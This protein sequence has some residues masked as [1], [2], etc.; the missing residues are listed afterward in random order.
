MSR[1]LS[2]RHSG[3]RVHQGCLLGGDGILSGINS[4]SPRIHVYPE[5]QDVTIF[6]NRV[7][8]DVIR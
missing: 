4:A 2:L 1:W 7:F 6:R 8:A 5:P 3:M